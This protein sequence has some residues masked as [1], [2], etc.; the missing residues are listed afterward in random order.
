MG[1][2]KFSSRVDKV[3][4]LAQQGF[5]DFDRALKEER[6][7]YWRFYFEVVKEWVDMEE[8]KH[9]TRKPDLTLAGG[10]LGL[11]LFGEFLAAR[12]HDRAALMLNRMADIIGGFTKLLVAVRLDEE[13]GMIIDFEIVEVPEVDQRK[14]DEKGRLLL[15]PAE[16]KSRIDELIDRILNAEEPPL[17]PIEM[18]QILKHRP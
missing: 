1:A 14:T 3:I 11:A 18:K 16:F 4:Q 6:G 2:D 7:K 17:L 5:E 9:R 8:E 13:S 15:T 12:K 10:S